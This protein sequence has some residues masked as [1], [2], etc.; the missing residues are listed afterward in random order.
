[1]F[2]THRVFCA[3]SWELEAERSAFH[4][5]VGDINETEAMARGVLLV[6]VSLVNIYDK[7]PLQ[8]VINENIRD[9]RCFLLALSE[10]WGP[11]ERHFER[12]YRLALACRE[13][14]TLPMRETAFLWQKPT[15]GSAVPPGLPAPTAE[16]ATSDEFKTHTQ[17]I[18]RGWLA[19]LI[20]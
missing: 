3:T 14:S 11:P 9:C 6:P 16:F 15:D 19:N 1:M 10:G 8:Y 12:D 13:D 17:T 20:A 5:V 2:Q 18:L 4:D 7:R